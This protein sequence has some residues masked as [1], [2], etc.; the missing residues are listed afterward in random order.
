MHGTKHARGVLDLQ[1]SR[2]AQSQGVV[3]QAFWHTSSAKSPECSQ[4]MVSSF[5]VIY[6]R[7]RV[8]N[9]GGSEIAL[10]CLP[11]R[12]CEGGPGLPVPAESAIRHSCSTSLPPIDQV[13]V[14]MSPAHCSRIFFVLESSA[15][16]MR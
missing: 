14:S 16:I 7:T 11:C 9:S 6:F 12:L 5:E 3:F 13:K 1:L 15:N 8:P 2:H 4:K 10:P